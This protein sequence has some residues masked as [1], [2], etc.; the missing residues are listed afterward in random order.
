M[1]GGRGRRHLLRAGALLSV[2]ALA[3]CVAG[4][5]DAQGDQ[6]QNPF[7]MPSG[8]GKQ[9][10]ALWVAAD[11]G[12]TSYPEDPTSAEDKMV[13]SMEMRD[14]FYKRLMRYRQENGAEGL[15][16]D[17]TGL[18][19][20]ARVHSQAMHENDY[21][22]V[23]APDGSA[24]SPSL[25]EGTQTHCGSV[26]RVVHSDSTT[27]VDADGSRRDVDSATVARAMFDEMVDDS[28]TNEKLLQ[29]KSENDSAVGVGFYVA[30]H[31]ADDGSVVADVYLTVDFCHGFEH[32]R[33]S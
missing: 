7:S 21:V 26:S 28:A 24:P 20:V 1:T 29:P 8:D 23:N 14:L 16:H 22:G 6:A 11:P 25:Y 10:D 13:G 4:G 15:Y 18:V 3:G 33:F 32:D 31:E 12:V 9:D 19:S 27:V 30:D 17:K 5:S 2:T